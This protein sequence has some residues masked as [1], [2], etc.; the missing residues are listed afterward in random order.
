M[1]TTPVLLVDVDAELA[2]LIELVLAPLDLPVLVAREREAALRLAR[3]QPPRAAIV[4]PG[5]LPALRALRALPGGAA[6]PGVILLSEHDEP[7]PLQPADHV[8][9]RPFR[10]ATLVQLLVP[11]RGAASP[12]E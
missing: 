5:Q 9:R 8:L 10:L 3:D 12:G 2:G 4:G 1:F 11:T 7:P 6:L